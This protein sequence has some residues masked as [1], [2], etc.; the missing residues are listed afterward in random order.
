MNDN[1]LTATELKRKTLRQLRA[2]RAAMLDLDYLLAL[3]ELPEDEQKMA[4]W[5]LAQVQLAYLQLRQAKLSEIGGRLRENAAALTQG[6]AALERQL[7]D[8]RKVR[9]VVAGVAEFLRIV[10]RV[11]GSR[12]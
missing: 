10:G 3:G 8:R 12:V 7:E 11:V 1:G 6:I 9:A 4:A 2:S 5:Q